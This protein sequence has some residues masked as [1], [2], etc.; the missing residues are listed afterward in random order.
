[1]TKE[2]NKNQTCTMAMRD[3]TSYIQ[4]SDPSFTSDK[5]KDSPLKTSTGEIKQGAKMPKLC[6]PVNF[7]QHLQDKQ[8]NVFDFFSFETNE[9]DIRP[10]WPSH[11]T[12]FVSKTK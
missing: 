11:V 4:A 8:Q 9:H 7:K 3:Q 5:S 12:E 6:G 10:E 2:S 1:M